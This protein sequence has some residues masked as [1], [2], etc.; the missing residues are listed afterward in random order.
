MKKKWWNDKVAYIEED[1]IY[2]YYRKLGDK[3]LLVIANYGK[4]KVSL[5]LKDIEGTV[6]ISNKKKSG[7]IKGNIDLL[8]CEVIV[9]DVY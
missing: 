6:I 4:E 2:S 8:S 1:T 7:S 3:K 5:K 9:I